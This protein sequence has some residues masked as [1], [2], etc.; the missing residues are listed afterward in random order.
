L[1]MPMQPR[2]LG[3]ARRVCA[4]T[5]N[6]VDGHHFPRTEIIGTAAASAT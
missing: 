1:A 3:Q 6:G 4:E 5:S 2:S